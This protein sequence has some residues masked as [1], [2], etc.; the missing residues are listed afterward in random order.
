MGPLESVR[1]SVRWERRPER[2]LAGVWLREK[3]A[4]EANGNSR[5]KRTG[6]KFLRSNSITKRDLAPIVLWMAQPTDVTNGS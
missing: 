3:V 2:V 1:R 5:R 6:S 4:A